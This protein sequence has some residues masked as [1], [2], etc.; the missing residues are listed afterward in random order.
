MKLPVI[1]LSL[2]FATAPL[3]AIA[4][5]ATPTGTAEP[6]VACTSTDF[7]LTGRP[8]L[9]GSDVDMG[10]TVCTG[11]STVGTLKYPSGQVV[12]VKP[13]SEAYLVKSVPTDAPDITL[14]QG[15]IHFTGSGKLSN[16]PDLYV[17]TRGAAIVARG[18]ELEVEH[19]ITAQAT[20]VNVYSG[21]VDVSDF[22]RQHTDYLHAGE[23]ARIVDGFAPVK[24]SFNPA[25]ANK[26]WLP[27][28]NQ[29]PAPSGDS[30]FPIAFIVT[31]V[32]LLCGAI[33]VWTFRR[34]IR[35]RL[36]NSR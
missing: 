9:V 4:D 28:N 5:K 35:A 30:I 27:S 15:A 29:S 10:A 6:G 13:N 20:T 11:T 8:A 19:D 34:Q 32:L 2:L 1:A 16:T 25:A 14:Y 23:S 26:W 33:A 17:L 7:K 18:T 22:I 36:F 12:Q 24:Q 21:E 3:P 31:G